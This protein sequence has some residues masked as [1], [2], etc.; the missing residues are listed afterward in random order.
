MPGKRQR[1][2]V[3]RVSEDSSL[4]QKRQRQFTELDEKFAQ[5]YEKLA[6]DSSD[7]RL[8]AAKDLLAELSS[9]ESSNSETLEKVLKR[10]IRGLCS[11]R[12]SA[13]YGFFVALTE[14]LRQKFG[15]DSSDGASTSSSIKELLSTIVSLTKTGGKVASQVRSPFCETIFISL[16]YHRRREITISVAY[17]PASL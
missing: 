16:L 9:E 11:G 14:L 17:M 6:D 12:K 2:P 7:V 15:N 13:R 1:D 4:N 3:A 10:L 5:I 8:A